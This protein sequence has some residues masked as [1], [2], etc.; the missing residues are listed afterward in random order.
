MVFSTL[1]K[2][3]AVFAAEADVAPVPPFAIGTVFN[4]NAPVFARVASPLTVLAIALAFASPTNILALANDSVR[5]TL[6]NDMIST[7]EPSGT[8]TPSS[9]ANVVPLTL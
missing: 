4:V 7:N 1:F 9:K 3:K 2:L 6:L 8:T 5:A